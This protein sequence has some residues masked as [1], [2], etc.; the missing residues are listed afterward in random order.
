MTLPKLSTLD[1]LITQY[2]KKFNK[3]KPQLEA[4]NKKIDD[5]LM[6]KIDLPYKEVENLRQEQMYLR[7]EHDT[8][9]LAIDNMIKM[10]QEIEQMQ[11][12][13]DH[14]TRLQQQIKRVKDEANDV[15]PPKRKIK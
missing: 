12:S 9:E 1:K 13:I 5:V 10:A 6:H 4:I 3:V 8:Y 15:L 2:Q 7:Y 11:D 14:I